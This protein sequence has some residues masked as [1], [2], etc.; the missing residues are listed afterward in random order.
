MLCASLLPCF[1]KIVKFFKLVESDV[2]P[3]AGEVC[4]SDL[5]FN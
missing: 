3:G 4:C 1:G 5:M 2:E